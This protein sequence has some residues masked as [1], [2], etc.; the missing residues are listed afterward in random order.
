MKYRKKSVAVD[1][2][3]FVGWDKEI[4]GTPFCQI[5]E[6]GKAFSDVPIWLEIAIDDGRIKTDIPYQGCIYVDTLEGYMCAD[7]GDYIIQ[8]VE[9][10]IYPCK[11]DIFE[12]TYEVV[13]K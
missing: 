7:E 8:G 11:P 6:S 9:G 12:K 4:E 3:Q 10:E 2:V 13:E 1:V 5:Y